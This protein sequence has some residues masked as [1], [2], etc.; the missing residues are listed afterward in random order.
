MDITGEIFL[1]IHMLT[2]S[3]TVILT[4]SSQGMGREIA[5]LLSQRGANLVL[6]SRNA[7]NL[8]SAVDYAKSHA[9]NPSTQRFTYISADVST[10]AE[11]IRILAEATAW[12]DGK[13]PEVVWAN[14][15]Y[16][17]PG[18]FLD[19]SF[20]TQRKQMDLNYWA[21]AYLAQHTFKAWLYPDVPHKKQEKG[22]KAEP[23]RHFIMTG[24]SLAFVNVAGYGAYSSAKAALRG[25]CEGLRYEVLL[26][27]GARRS[28]AQTKFAPA[29]FDVN[30]QIVYPGGIDSPGHTNEELTKPKVTRILEEA[31]PLQSEISAATAAIQGLEK[32]QFSS[33][34]NYLGELMRISALGSTPRQNIIK[35]VVGTWITSIAWLFIWP[36]MDGKAW[37]HGKKEGMPEPEQT[38]F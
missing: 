31:D 27:N 18:L 11:N 37:G 15:G 38:K 1:T 12:N 25:L 28:N 7:Q 3:K 17:V 23:S 21:A 13:T 22:A 16:S 10:E 29:P 2:I 26:Y 14:A 19:F 33:P 6:V 9:K 24:S 36:D 4:G 5:K 35:D 32:G 34:T 30:V 20:E 8:Q